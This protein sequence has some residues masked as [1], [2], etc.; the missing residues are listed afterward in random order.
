MYGNII[1]GKFTFYDSEWR[2][3]SDAARHLVATMLQELLIVNAHL[4]ERA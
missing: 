2:V 1:Q 4:P 3:V